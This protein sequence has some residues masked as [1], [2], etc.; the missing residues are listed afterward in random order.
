LKYCVLIIDGAAGLPLPQHRNQTCLELARTPNLDAMTREGTLGTVRNVPA[1]MEPSSACACM[2]IL[3][4]DP[5]AY[6]RGRA[7]IEAKSL[8]IP[9]GDGEVVFRCNLVS[10]SDGQMQDYI[11]IFT[12]RKAICRN[13]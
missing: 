1:G 6:Y 7:A 10:V 5:Q 2:S 12:C 13:P 8:G 9:I 4:Y 3:G 11:L